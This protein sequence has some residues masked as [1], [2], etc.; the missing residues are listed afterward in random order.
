ML[1]M[2]YSYGNQRIQEDLSRKRGIEL[3]G[4]IVDRLDNWERLIDGLVPLTQSG[5]LEESELESKFVAS[6][7]G[8]PN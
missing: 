1:S 4:A 3:F 2:L 7:R 6:V 8:T 5:R